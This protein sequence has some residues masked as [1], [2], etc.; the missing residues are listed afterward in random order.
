MPISKLG[1][2]FPLN[3]VAL[4]SKILEL[5]IYLGENKEKVQFQFT[6]AI[7]IASFSV[8]FFFFSV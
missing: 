5:V 7:Y 8:S 3:M 2:F 4:P 1:V 6:E